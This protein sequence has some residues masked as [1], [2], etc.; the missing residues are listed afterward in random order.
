M[1]TLPFL[2]TR[3]SAL[4]LAL[5]ALVAAACGSSDTTSTPTT[6]APP[7]TTTPPATTAPTTAANGLSVA[8][9]TD[10][11]AVKNAGT[12]TVG[13]DKPGYPPYIIDD[14]PT[15]GKGF[16]S[17]VAYAIATKLG[18]TK[19]QVKWAV[20]PFDSSYKPGSK[21]FD[22]DINQ[23]GISDDRKK[24]VDFSDPYYSAPQSVIT[25]EGSKIAGA[26]SIADLANAKLGVQLGTTS[27]NATADVLKVK[28]Q[29]F[30]TTGQATTALKN[31]QID[32][33]VMDLPSGLY[34]ANAV[35]TK[36]KVLGQFAAPGG[37]N[38]GLLVAKGSALTPC[39]NEAMAAITSSGELTQIT[40]QW[41]GGSTAAELK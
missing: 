8:C 33:I 31:H 15:N 19:D 9:G 16:E 35:L 6:A 39:L 23:I 37:D 38:W 14:T 4:A 1:R 28:A 20:V 2:R 18:F 25:I 22:F 29:V 26:T 36:G 11:L 32:G 10:Q 12:L 41:M 21:E 3:A 5:I 27:L 7:A 34:T 24:A 17:A 13:T 40:Q 30:D